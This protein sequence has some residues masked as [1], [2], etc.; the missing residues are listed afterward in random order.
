MSADLLMTPLHA[1]HAL[2]V[3]RV[4]RARGVWGLKSKAA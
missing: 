3:E 4:Y 1:L 2:M